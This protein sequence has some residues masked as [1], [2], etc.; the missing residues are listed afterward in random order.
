MCVGSLVRVYMPGRRCTGSIPRSFLT[1][2]SS[3]VF[4]A[5]LLCRS[6]FYHRHACILP[7][8]TDRYNAFA[9]WQCGGRKLLDRSA[10]HVPG[11]PFSKGDSDGR[12]D[13]GMRN[14]RTDGVQ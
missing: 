14:A 11:L 12:S 2:A 3:Y 4:A 1:E 5:I 6:T 13:N 7:R 10:I 8:A 9:V